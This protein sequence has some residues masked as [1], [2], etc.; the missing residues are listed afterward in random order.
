LPTTIAILLLESLRPIISRLPFSKPNDLFLFCFISPS[1]EARSWNVS[2][3]YAATTT[4]AAAA[5]AAATRSDVSD[6]TWRGNYLLQAN[7][8]RVLPDAKLA[9]IYLTPPLLRQF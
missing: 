4:A 8:L 3:L 6:Y 1:E 5:A 7:G 2:F 9:V